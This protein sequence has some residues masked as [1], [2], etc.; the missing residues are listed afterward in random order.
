MK[1]TKQQLQELIILVKDAQKNEKENSSKDFSN[2]VE[3][4]LNKFYG[5]K[6]EKEKK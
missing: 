1:I 6:I 3:N 4:F 2:R 5:V